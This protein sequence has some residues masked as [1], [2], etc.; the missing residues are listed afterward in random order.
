MKS[1]YLV[2][3]NTNVPEEGLRIANRD[4]WKQILQKN[5]T[6]PVE[7][8]RFFI[9]D[10]ILD[11][12]KMDRMF[13]ETSREKFDEWHREKMKRIRKQQDQSEVMLISGDVVVGT[14]GETVFDT[15]ASSVNVEKE[16]EEKIHLQTLRNE[17]SAW[18][19][20]AGDFFDLYINGQRKTSCSI[21][22][23]KYGVTERTARSWKG[24]FEIYIAENLKP[25]ENSLPF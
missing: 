14:D 19:E 17:L 2:Y 20:W 25:F 24:K 4:E 12:G 8:R 15:I 10:R 23:Q 18:H 5:K 22:C 1:T 7:K 6:L 11:M 21:I 9:E 13:I 16:V 3:K